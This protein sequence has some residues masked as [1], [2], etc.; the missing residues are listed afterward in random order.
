MLMLNCSLKIWSRQAC[1]HFRQVSTTLCRRYICNRISS[2]VNSDSPRKMSFLSIN[3]ALFS[4]WWLVRIWVHVMNKD[5]TNKT[6]RNYKLAFGKIIDQV[7]VST[8]WHSSWFLPNIFQI[9]IQSSDLQP[10]TAQGIDTAVQQ[11]TS[12]WTSRY[13]YK[14]YNLQDHVLL[15]PSAIAT[16]P[17]HL[18]VYSV[19]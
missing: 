13:F 5:A 6:R 12:P 4:H 16:R 9:T 3:R 10:Y 7:I 8:D 11:H 1:V 2:R 15:F 17:F 14:A 19:S 18:N